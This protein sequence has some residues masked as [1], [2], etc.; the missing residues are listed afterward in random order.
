[1]MSPAAASKAQVLSLGVVKHCLC[2]LTSLEWQSTLAQLSLNL[3]LLLSLE[4]QSAPE[5]VFPPDSVLPTSSVGKQQLL[6]I[7]C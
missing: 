4:R 3:A 7:C 2:F 5:G 1:M 6:S